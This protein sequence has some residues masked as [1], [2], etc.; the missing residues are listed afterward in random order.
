MV[1]DGPDTEHK[2]REICVTYDGEDVAFSVVDVTDK[3][4][5]KTLSNTVYEGGAYSHQGWFTEDQATMLLAD[6]LDE[7]TFR[8]K[9]RT[10]L[11]DM[12]DLDAPKALPN[13]MWDSNATEH[14]VYIKGQRAYFANYTEGFRL[15]DVSAASSAVLKEVAF[16]DTNPNSS[17]NDMSGAWG[18]FP[19][20]TSGLVA[21]GDIVSGLFVL[22]PQPA[23]LG[24]PAN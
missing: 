7:Q 10:Y 6:E 21:V 20:F 13:H 4:A 17:S 16:F 3:S 23:S 15:L 9:T 18:A 11:F 14:N 1:Y 19:Y 12:T 5:P 22:K 8:R 24:T 2:G